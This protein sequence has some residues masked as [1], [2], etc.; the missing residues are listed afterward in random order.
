MLVLATG[1]KV[2]DPGN[3][4]KYPMK[5]R[6]GKDLETFWRENR[7]QAYEGVSVPDFPNYFMV[8]GPYG[9]NGSSYFNLVETQSRHIVRALSHARERGATL[10]EV[11][12]EANDRYFAEMLRRRKRQI[13]WQESCG[14]ANSYYFD[15]HGDVPLRPVPTIETMWRARRYPLDDYRYERL[16][17]VAP[18]AANVPET[19]L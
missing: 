12:E 16:E 5:G 17:R 6:G 18:R 19:V 9:Y 13:F 8:M 10:I 1:F 14:G 3:F 4:P 7:F 2:F 15:D 11:S